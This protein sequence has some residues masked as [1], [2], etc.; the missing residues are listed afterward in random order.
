ME[1]D[2]RWSGATGTIII[3]GVTARETGMA[4]GSAEY[5]LPL[6]KLRDL[7]KAGLLRRKRQ[8][9]T[10]PFRIVHGLSSLKLLGKKFLFPGLDLHTRCRYQ[11]LPSLICGGDLETL[12]AGFGNG[13]LSY[14][15]YR[16]GNRILGVSFSQREV[17][18]TR[19]FFDFLHVPRQRAEFQL[20]NIYHLRQLNRKFDQIICTE[21]LEHISRDKEVV[22]IFSD[23]LRPGGRLILCCP[24]Q[25]HPINALG[26][27]DEPE[28]G[29]HVRD[30]YTLE[31]YR[32][33]LDPVGLKITK[34]VGLGFPLLCRLELLLQKTRAWLGD[35]G[36]L[37]LFF[38]MLPLT[39]LDRPDPPVP[40]SLCVTAEKQVPPCGFAS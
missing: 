29:G 25:R 12:D 22:Q 2:W 9:L 32:S 1:H 26:R 7:S 34:T 11:S 13:A 38:F 14:A 40:L 18:A 17:T 8:R 23:L 6:P 28:T 39:W 27:T 3:I 33:L 31:S 30:G 21:T 35:I 15:A 20:M 16:K 4:N 36:S 10:D 19:A 5:P 24:Y 37:P